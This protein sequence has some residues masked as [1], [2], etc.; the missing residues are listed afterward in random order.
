MWPRTKRSEHVDILVLVP[1]LQV[2]PAPRLQNIIPV[3][4]IVYAAQLDVSQHSTV[5]GRK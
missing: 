2:V 1:V 3:M 5:I 4:E